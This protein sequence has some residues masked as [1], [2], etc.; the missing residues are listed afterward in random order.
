MCT[1]HLS[2]SQWYNTIAK[3]DEYLST[4][5]EQNLIFEYLNYTRLQLLGHE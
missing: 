4:L 3:T 2:F 1:S 5:D